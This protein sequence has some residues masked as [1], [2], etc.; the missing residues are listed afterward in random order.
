MWCR[1]SAGCPRGLTPRYICT[2]IICPRLFRPTREVEEIQWSYLDDMPW[3]AVVTM[4]YRAAVASGLS[5]IRDPHPR[6]G[7]DLTF[8]RT[9]P[10]CWYAV[11]HVSSLSMLTN[12]NKNHEPHP[13]CMVEGNKVSIRLCNIDDRYISKLS[14]CRHHHFSCQH[15]DDDK[16]PCTAICAVLRTIQD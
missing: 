12:Q 9:V 8:T 3:H 4:I 1:A 16:K 6:G 5:I 11:E 2:M 14:W 7:Y 10:R 13:E 15:D